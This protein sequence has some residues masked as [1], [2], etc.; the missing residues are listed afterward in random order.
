MVQSRV[1]VPV[2]DKMLFSKTIP[3]LKARPNKKNYKLHI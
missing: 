2:S 1:V 3:D